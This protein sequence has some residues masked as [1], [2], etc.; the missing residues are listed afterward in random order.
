MLVS[1]V[2]ASY[3]GF[4]KN[5]ASDRADKLRRAIASFIRQDHVEK[6]L[7]IVADGCEQ[8]ESIFFELVAPSK[9]DDFY[10][11]KQLNIRQ[12]IPIGVTHFDV[13]SF[14][15]ISIPKQKSFSGKVRNYGVE[16]AKG[17]IVCYLDN[18]DMLLQNHLSSIV[19]HFGNNDWVYFDD[20]IAG[21]AALK[22]VRPRINFL[23]EGMVGTSSIAHRQ[24]LE[25]K[26]PDG[27]GHDWKFIEALKEKYPKYQKINGPEYVVCH[28]P[29]QI[30]F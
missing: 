5:S 22:T 20:M 30:D 6:E 1:V 16:Y 28:I 10:L 14:K 17:V 11:M 26:W 24:W 3:I 25:V 4:Y 27:Y 9:Y 8:T 21:D 12:G 13:G 18:D 2:M 29:G 23:S 7:I 19:W 15:I